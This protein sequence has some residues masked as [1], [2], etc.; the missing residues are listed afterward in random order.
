MTTYS[1]KTQDIKRE[2]HLFDADDKILGRLATELAEVLMGKNKV[3]FA[4][5]L[6]IGDF[7]VVINAKKVKVTGKKEKAKIYY[8]H[9]GYPGGLK[10]TPLGKMRQE[11]PERIIEHAVSGMLPKNKLR[12]KMMARLKVFAGEEHSFKDKF[13]AKGGSTSG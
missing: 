1:T 9:S 6:D 4:R 8:H 12:D 7:V 2:W 10:E 11:H 13:S 3:Y 5:H